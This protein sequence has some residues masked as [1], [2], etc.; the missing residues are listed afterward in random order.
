MRNSVTTHGGT[1]LAQG[2]SPLT[3]KHYREQTANPTWHLARHICRWALMYK[4]TTN[5]V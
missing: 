1:S 5:A 2:I 4:G 3:I